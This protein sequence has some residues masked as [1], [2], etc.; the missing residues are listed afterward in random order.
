QDPDRLPAEDYCRNRKKK[1]M[2]ELLTRFGTLLQTT[3]EARGAL[4]F[5]TH[6]EPARFAATVNDCLAAF[7]PWQTDCHVP[8]KF[9]P[10]ETTLPAFSV[11]RAD[12]DAAHAVE[13]KRYHALLHPDCLARLLRALGYAPAAERLD[14]PRFYSAASNDKGDTDNDYPAESVSLTDR[15]RAELLDYLHDREQ[16]RK[17]TKATQLRF[18]A[19]GHELARLDLGQTA[20]VRFALREYA[21]FLEIRTATDDLLLATHQLRYDDEDRLLPEEAVIVLPNGDRLAFTTSPANTITVAD[22]APTAQSSWRQ[23]FDWSVW[24]EAPRWQPVFA[25]A[26]LLLLAASFFYWLAQRTAP[27]RRE[28]VYTASP[29]PTPQPSPTAAVTPTSPPKSSATPLISDD[30]I[31]TNL[32]TRASDETASLT[33]GERADAVTLLAARKLYLDLSADAFTQSL[34]TQLVERLNT[35]TLTANPDEA[36]IA[37]KVNATSVAPNRLTLIA[38]IVDANGKVIWPLTPRVSG[39]KYEGPTDKTLDQFSRELARDVQ[40]LKQK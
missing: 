26:L 23:W 33:R 1:L 19:H 22:A 17:Q 35:F 38:R 29:T 25:L 21:E 20:P 12:S 34:R 13:I 6:D 31:A 30:V 37:L 14:I 39:R 2:E 36:D 24:F 18:V 40:Q 15:E 8:E 16:R 4:R 27:P 28:I 32:R 7:T 3:Q 10:L 5:V 9:S 11:E